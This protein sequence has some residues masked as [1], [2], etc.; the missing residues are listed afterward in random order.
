M[1]LFR[2]TC[3]YGGISFFLLYRPPST[4]KQNVP[5]KFSSIELSCHFHLFRQRIIYFEPFPF[6]VFGNSINGNYGAPVPQQHSHPSRIFSHPIRLPPPP[7]ELI[8][9]H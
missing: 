1:E 9:V 2:V 5:T 6:I 4:A 3:F 7:P 8:A